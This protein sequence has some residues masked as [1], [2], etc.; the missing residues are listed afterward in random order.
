MPLTFRYEDKLNGSMKTLKWQKW[1]DNMALLMEKVADRWCR[2]PAA[3]GGSGS[4][5]VRLN[6][7]LSL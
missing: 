7:W 2:R 5:L 3:M 6:V 1:Y 4:L